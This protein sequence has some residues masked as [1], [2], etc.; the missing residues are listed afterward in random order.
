MTR[1][2]LQALFPRMTVVDNVRFGP[3]SKKRSKA[4][5]EASVTDMLGANADDIDTLEAHATS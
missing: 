2:Q 3:R 1:E 4:D 5:C